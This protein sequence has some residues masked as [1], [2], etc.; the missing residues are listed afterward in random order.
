M[1]SEQGTTGI[2]GRAASARLDPQQLTKTVSRMRPEIKQRRFGAYRHGSSIKP[3]RATPDE[4][5]R[6][7]TVINATASDAAEPAYWGSRVLEEPSRHDDIVLDQEVEPFRIQVRCV[8]PARYLEDAN[9]F[10]S[11]DPGGIKCICSGQSYVGT[12]RR[13]LMTRTEP[14]SIRHDS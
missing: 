14:F 8:G 9:G 2:I 12:A 5:N 6:S 4:E 11:C 10:D 7:V 3:D 1:V 13:G